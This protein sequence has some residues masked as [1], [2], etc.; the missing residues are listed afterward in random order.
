MTG[1]IGVT[2][3]ETPFELPRIVAVT[4]PTG[5][6]VAFCALTIGAAA[7]ITA[8]RE[9]MAVFSF[10]LLWSFGSGKGKVNGSFSENFDYECGQCVQGNLEGSACGFGETLKR[11]AVRATGKLWKIPRNN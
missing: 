7:R 5:S 1:E 11:Q 8:A 3:K 4:N 2:A 9:G 6:V 10:M